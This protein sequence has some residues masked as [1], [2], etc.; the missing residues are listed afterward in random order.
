[1]KKLLTL[2]IA[3]IGGYAIF[4]K[5]QEANSDR[6]LWAEVTDAVRK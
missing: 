5:V 6:D 3:S 2:I 1:V 4:K